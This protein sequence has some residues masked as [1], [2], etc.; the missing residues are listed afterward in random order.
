M[1]RRERQLEERI[2]HLEI[3]VKMEREWNQI[4]EQLKPTSKGRWEQMKG[5]LKAQESR[6]LGWPKNY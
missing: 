2:A 3:E 5:E 1:D 6:R 4:P